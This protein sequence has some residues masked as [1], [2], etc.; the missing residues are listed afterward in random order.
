MAFESSVKQKH[1]KPITLSNQER[2][3]LASDKTKERLLVVDF[4]KDV[5]TSAVNSESRGVLQQTV[6]SLRENTSE[7]LIHTLEEAKKFGGISSDCAVDA[8]KIIEHLIGTPPQIGALGSE[9]FCQ[10]ALSY[11]DWKKD[12]DEIMMPAFPGR[13]CP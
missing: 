6:L 12:N 2:I 9:E 3:V 7:M 4:F 8:D 10:L 13:L 11:L 1:L 5:L